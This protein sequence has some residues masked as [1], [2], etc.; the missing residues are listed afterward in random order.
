MA[1]NV[2]L[3]LSYRNVPRRERQEMVDEVLERFGMAGRRELRPPQLSGGQQQLVAVARAVAGRPRLV[4]AD[5]PTGNLHSRHGEQVMEIFRRL[6]AEGATILQ[7]THHER[8]AEYAARVV[9][10]EDGRIVA[11]RPGT[12]P[13]A[14]G[15]A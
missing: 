4:L 14:D 11:D 10:L 2:E 8:F 9:E 1:E 6:N 12:P 13:G 7:A 5:E 15:P 3:P